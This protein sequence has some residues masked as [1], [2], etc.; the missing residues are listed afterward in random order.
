MEVR[1]KWPPAIMGHRQVQHSILS[2]FEVKRSNGGI[3]ES[4]LAWV[5][6]ERIRGLP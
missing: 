4:C 2:Q 1:V 6:P 5:A 3:E